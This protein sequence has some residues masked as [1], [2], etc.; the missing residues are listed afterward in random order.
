MQEIKISKALSK[1]T[2]PEHPVLV[3]AGSMDEETNIMVA[4]WVMRTSNNPPMVAVSVGHTRYTHKLLD[5]Y[6]EYVLSYP[7]KGQ[8]EIIEFCGTESGKEHDKFKELKLETSPGK[9]V[10]LPIINEARVNFECK[11]VNKVKTGDHTVFIG[12]VISSSGNPEKNPL[13]NIGGYKYREFKFD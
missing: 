1:L 7:V 12:E 13:L 3:I 11:I 8:E 4:G 6:S 2:K 9:K 10:N 5:K